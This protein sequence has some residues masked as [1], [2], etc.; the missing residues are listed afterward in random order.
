ML[1]PLPG[2]PFLQITAWLSTSLASG[3]SPHAPCCQVSDSS[4]LFGHHWPTVS[5]WTC[6]PHADATLTVW[7][8][9]R[10]NHVHSCSARRI[11]GPGLCRTTPVP[12]WPLVTASEAT[13]NIQSGQSLPGLHCAQ[14]GSPLP[15]PQPQLRPPHCLQA[16]G[17]HGYQY[18]AIGMRVPFCVLSCLEVP[19][20]S[21]FPPV[22]GYGHLCASR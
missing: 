2:A 19:Q 14:L 1:C 21:D 5:R 17:Q 7:L 4:G 13:I 15:P 8:H 12:C 16:S 6:L 11:W 18:A 20:E 10:K 9:S 3:D 22:A